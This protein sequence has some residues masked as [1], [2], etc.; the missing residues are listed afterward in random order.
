MNT[1]NKSFQGCGEKGNLYAFGGNVNWYSHMENSM[2]SLKKLKIELPYD[3]VFPLSN[4][5]KIKTLI[6]KDTSIHSIYKINMLQGYIV[7]YR[8][9]GLSR[10]L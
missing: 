8:E 1:N 4:T 2:R 9:Y 7:Q 6:Q 3:L 5:K 10:W